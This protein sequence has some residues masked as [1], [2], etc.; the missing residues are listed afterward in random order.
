MCNHSPRL[1]PVLQAP[2]IK[3][4]CKCLI[5]GW[6]YLGLK[7]CNMSKNRCT[8]WATISGRKNFS[9]P[10]FFSHTQNRISEKMEFNCVCFVNIIFVKI[11]WKA[12]QAPIKRILQELL[13]VSSFAKQIF[14]KYPDNLS[15]SIKFKKPVLYFWCFK[16]YTYWLFSSWKAV[17]I[18]SEPPNSGWTCI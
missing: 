5:D 10:Q 9:A 3:D 15:V 1:C 16:T 14:L 2:G 13:F 17:T 7:E 6:E 11:V 18:S 8:T 12:L 4:G